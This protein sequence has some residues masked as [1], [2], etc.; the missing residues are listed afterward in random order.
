MRNKV[1]A[2][3]IIS[4]TSLVVL[5]CLGFA[6]WD[7]FRSHRQSF[8]YEK[9]AQRNEKALEAA[10]AAAREV[11]RAELRKR[12]KALEK[13]RGAEA[14]R[15]REEQARQRRA[16]TYRRFFGGGEFKLTPLYAEACKMPEGAPSSEDQE[17]IDLAGDLLTETD[18]DTAAD[19]TEAALKSA[20]PRARIAAVEMLSAMGDV[21]LADIAE[22]LTDSH[23]EV[24]NLA[25]DRWELGVQDVMDEGERTALVKVGLLAITDTDQLRSMVG[26]LLLTTDELLVIQ[27]VA[28]VMRDGRKVQRE[29]VREAYEN[30]T[31]EPWKDEAT[32][33]AWLRE[34]YTPPE[35]DEPS[36]DEDDEPP[37]SE[38]DADSA[39]DM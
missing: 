34:N 17:I 36:E 35:P 28:D 9:V 6:V 18:L 38:E 25:A 31:G 24:A 15:N 5:G 2:C 13:E 21:G 32:A 19:V 1:I 39:E 27:T 23:P 29:A 3:C 11:V 12:E 37:D 16:A 14:V 26:T 10:K 4:V 20:D 7:G 33:E 22:F 30:V 8:E